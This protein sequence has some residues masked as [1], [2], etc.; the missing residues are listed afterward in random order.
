MVKFPLL[1]VDPLT[2][3]S[4]LLDVR[5]EVLHKGAW[6]AALLGFLP[7]DPGP[8]KDQTLRTRYLVKELIPKDSFVDASQENI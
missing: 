7:Q 8:L 6:V 4:L 5:I 1:T 3:F 2:G